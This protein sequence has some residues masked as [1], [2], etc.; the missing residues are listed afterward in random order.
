MNGRGPFQCKGRG[1]AARF[2]RKGK[3]KSVR[4]SL[5]RKEGKK[6][7]DYCASAEKEKRRTL[8]PK[9]RKE[10]EKR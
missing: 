5:M 2:K 9:K 4:S 3:A 6:N 10:S 7:G 8:E 1:V